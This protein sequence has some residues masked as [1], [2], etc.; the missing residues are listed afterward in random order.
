MLT[1]YFSNHPQ[2]LEAIKEVI[3]DKNV[4]VGYRYSLLT[5]ALRILKSVDEK[6]ELKKEILEAANVIEAPKVTYLS[7]KK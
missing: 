5:R 1:T 3:K 7:L 2:A 4:R 6:D